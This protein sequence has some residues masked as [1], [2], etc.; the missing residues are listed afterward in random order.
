M[1]LKLLSIVLFLMVMSFKPPS[2]VNTVVDLATLSTPTS[3]ELTAFDFARYKSLGLTVTDAL[4]GFITMASP[5]GY[6]VVTGYK[7]M[8][9]GTLQDYSIENGLFS[10]DEYDWNMNIIPTTDFTD[11]IQRAKQLGDS[12]CNWQKYF[13]INGQLVHFQ[14]PKIFPSGSVGYMNLGQFYTEADLRTMPNKE[15]FQA[16][17]T[18]DEHLYDN[19]WFPKEGNGKSSLLGRTIGVYGPWV[20]DKG[21]GTRP[22]IHPC[23]VIW[24]K[25]SSAHADT[26][27]I[28][29]IQDDSNRFDDAGDFSGSSVPATNIWAKPP[30]KSI[31]KI[32]FEYNGK[33]RDHLVIDIEEL[34]S[35]NVVTAE[36]FGFQDSDD[37]QQHMLKL[38][39]GTLSSAL[40]NNTMVEVNEK[41]SAGGNIAVSFVD[42]K[43]KLDG[44]IVGYIQLKTA[45]GRSDGSEGYQVLKVT[46]KYAIMP[47]NLLISQ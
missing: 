19:V 42:V 36:Q 20:Y 30:M 3:A 2:N 18:P 10:G 11:V 6:P 23:E 22:E 21:H 31:Y 16:E 9:C 8:G 25:G 13:Q 26:L 5:A 4:G 14:C 17:I 34:K 12:N 27:T 15:F 37:G 35:L 1:K 24:W 46:V 44:N 7:K 28:M 32:P 43:K 41:Q 33:F 38:N 40:L 29:G 39:R 47:V 45:Y